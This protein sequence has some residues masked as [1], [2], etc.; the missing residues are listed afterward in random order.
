MNEAVAATPRGFRHD[1]RRGLGSALLMLRSSAAP[2]DYVE[3][4]RWACLH[5]TT[6]DYQCEGGRGWYLHQA[7]T[8]TGSAQSIEAEVIGRFAVCSPDKWRFDYL[9]DTLVLFALDGSER[10][11]KTLWDSYSRLM[12]RFARTVRRDGWWPSMSSLESLALDLTRVDGWEA[13]RTALSDFGDSLATGPE[14]PEHARW[15]Y[16]PDWFDS[17]VREQFG[18][19]TV[20]AYLADQP[21]P[22]RRAYAETAAVS[23]ARLES[24]GQRP[25]PTLELFVDL[26]EQVRRDQLASRPP[27]SAG[28]GLR[29]AKMRFWPLGMRLRSVGRRLCRHDPA[30]AEQVAR[31][32]LTESD[33]VVKAAI[34]RLFWKQTFPLPD[35]DLAPLVD[36]DDA[37]L[38]WAVRSILGQRPA[39]WKRR[40]ALQLL[41]DRE[42]LEQVDEALELLQASYRPEDEPVVEAAV[43]RVSLRHSAWHSVYSQV[44]DLLRPDDRPVTTGVLEHVYRQTLCSCCRE[45]TVRLMRDKQALPDTIVRECLW[46]SNDEIRD[47]AAQLTTT[48]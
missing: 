27:Q 34:L 46:D 11:R 8:L 26:V 30:A 23:R 6:Y 31:L 33:P 32:G 24:S 1:L 9:T 20:D 47:L 15:Q 4:V 28:P 7:A 17:A 38:R 37:E 29:P 19:A 14:A 41:Q 21:S 39:D 10:S 12:A 40:H 3:A 48:D 2:Q 18:E 16:F 25:E 35:A 22:G 13:A 5:M 43:R 45:S 44:L 42:Q 36:A